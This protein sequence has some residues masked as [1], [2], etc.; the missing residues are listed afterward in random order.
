MKTNYMNTCAVSISINMLLVAFI[1]MLPL[2]AMA[3]NVTTVVGLPDDATAMSYSATTQQYIND[4]SV[5]LH[6]P[7]ASKATTVIGLP[8]DS[9]ALQQ[10]KTRFAGDTMFR[11]ELSHFFTD[12]FTQET[13][14]TYGTIWFAKDRY[15]IETP[16]Q[17]IVVNGNTSTVLNIR[18]NRIII[19]H[20]D[21]EEDEF[22]PSR[23]FASDNDAYTSSDI[24]NPDGTTSINITSDDPFELF[25]SVIIKV[26]RDGSPMQIDAIDQMDNHIQTTFRFGRFSQ[27]SAERFT[28][29]PPAGAE[30]VDLRD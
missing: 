23:F 29:T 18:Q 27:I 7:M 10:L 19:S 24:T 2:S 15:R 3:S 17:I 12:S 5:P 11:A 9:P 8:N 4:I 1:W 16:D 13:T 22:A 26:S 25:Q 6:S 20:Y 30:I 21:S 28:L 14:E